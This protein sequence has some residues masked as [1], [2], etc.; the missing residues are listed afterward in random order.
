MSVRCRLHTGPREGEFR[1][2]MYIPAPVYDPLQDGTIVLEQQSMQE[3][4]VPSAR[5]TTA[6]INL[7][8]ARQ[9]TN[10]LLRLTP[11]EHGN[12]SHRRS[13]DLAG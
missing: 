1:I 9:D 12:R 10:R 6:Q 5:C 8:E 11:K 13:R 2:E 7:T 4:S 3:R